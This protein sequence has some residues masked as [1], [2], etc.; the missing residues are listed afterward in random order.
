[1]GQLKGQYS[2]GWESNDLGYVYASPPPHITT[3]VNDTHK[4]NLTI[5]CL[6]AT[7][8]IWSGMFCDVRIKYKM[9][10]VQI[11]PHVVNVTQYIA[12]LRAFNNTCNNMG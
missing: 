12:A 7:I 2:G 11:L 5:K 10:G 8:R 1:M 6:A 9:V 4:S 3:T